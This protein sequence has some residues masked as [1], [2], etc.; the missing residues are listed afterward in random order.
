MSASINNTPAGLTAQLEGMHE[1]F[2][3]SQPIPFVL[4][5]GGQLAVWHRLCSFKGTTDYLLAP[6]SPLA[7]FWVDSHMYSSISFSELS[8]K[9]IALRHAHA[10]EQKTGPLP[11]RMQDSN[12]QELTCKGAKAARGA[13]QFTPEPPVDAT[14]LPSACCLPAHPVKTYAEHIIKTTRF[15]YM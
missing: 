2:P 11:D 14:V 4:L 3:G 7:R 13:S 9:C 6:S 12:H 15:Q 8:H 5:C 1:V 10:V